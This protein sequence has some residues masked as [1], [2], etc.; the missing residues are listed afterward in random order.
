[1]FC[2]CGGIFEYFFKFIEFLV[3]SQKLILNS[4]CNFLQFFNREKLANDIDKFSILYRV[5]VEHVLLDSF[6]PNNDK[7]IVL[8]WWDLQRNFRLESNDEL[9][10]FRAN[11]LLKMLFFKMN[12]LS[13]IAKEYFNVIDVH[14][15][16]EHLVE[17]RHFLILKKHTV[18]V[19]I[20]W[21]Y[22]WF[23]ICY[24]ETPLNLILQRRFCICNLGAL[25][26]G[27]INVVFDIFNDKWSLVC[28]LVKLLTR[29]KIRRYCSLVAPFSFALN[30]KYFEP[31]NFL[32]SHSFLEFLQG[33][34]RR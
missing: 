6:T 12:S 28:L 30:H 10:L 3:I 22:F 23:L 17:F 20:C 25:I 15:G 2:C 16:S 19:I 21:L 5:I 7:S 9:L 1:M 14:F 8:F 34:L 18:K 24:G 29:I 4:K 27:Q 11:I 31:V 26:N 32:C 13:L 33:H